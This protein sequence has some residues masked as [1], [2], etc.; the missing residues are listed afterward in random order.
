MP[1]DRLSGPPSGAEPDEDSA[2]EDGESEDRPLLD[3][4]RAFFARASS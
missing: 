1:A 3:R 4:L 2:E